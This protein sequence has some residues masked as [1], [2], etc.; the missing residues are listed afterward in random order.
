MV[1]VGPLQGFTIIELAGLG[2]APMAGMLFADMGAEVIRVERGTHAANNQLRDV[3]LRGKKSIA[4]DLKKLAGID[5]LLKLVEKAD[6]LIEGYR[7]GVTERLGIG[8]EACQRR[9]PKLVYGRITG[10]GQDGP[11]AKAAGHD[12]NYI[13]LSGALHA[14]GRNGERPAPPLNLIGDM[15]GGGML[16]ALG[17]VCALLEAQRSGKGQVIDAAMVDGAAQLMWM[18]HGFNAS[19]TWRAQERGVNLLDGGAHFYDTYETADGRYVAVGAIEPQF[20]AELLKRTGADPAHFADQ[21]NARLWPQMKDKL[22]A[23]IKSKTRDQWAAI[24]EGTDACFAP[25]LSLLEAPEHHHMR[26]RNTFIEV[27][28]VMQ[29]APAPRFSRTTSRVRHGSRP[30]G[31]DGTAVLLAAGMPPEE[32]EKLRR[33]GVLIEGSPRERR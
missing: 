28:G 30:L 13:A 17:V 15:G 8:P 22:G 14:I 1:R 32:I 6:A 25:V 20:Y 3:S 23:I 5:A 26:A 12:I 11:L 16:L 7:P 19:G 27:E 24:M 4:L 31:A 21:R 9:N 18:I 10:W 2:P 29:A 33:D